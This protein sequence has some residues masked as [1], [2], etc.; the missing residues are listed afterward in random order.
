MGRIN[1]VTDKSPRAIMIW[2]Y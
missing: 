2:G 1:G